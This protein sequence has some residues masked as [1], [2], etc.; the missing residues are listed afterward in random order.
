MKKQAWLLALSASV[1]MAACG[2]NNPTPSAS[3]PSASDS[4]DVSSSGDPSTESIDLSNSEVSVDVSTSSAEGSSAA[5]LSG[6]EAL[7][8]LGRNILL[9][10]VFS[11]AVLNTYSVPIFALASFGDDFSEYKLVDVIDGQGVW[12]T[13]GVV[14][15]VDQKGLFGYTY[16]AGEITI[17]KCAGNTLTPDN[18]LADLGY[19]APKSFLIQE[20]EMIEL[21]AY[22]IQDE[23]DEYAWEAFLEDPDTEVIFAPILNEICYDLIGFTYTL[24]AG[25]NYASVSEMKLVTSDTGDAGYVSATIALDPS[26]AAYYGLPQEFSGLLTLDNFDGGFSTQEGTLDQVLLSAHIAAE[27]FAESDDRPGLAANWGDLNAEFGNGIGQYVP[28]PA[29]NTYALAVDA[30]YISMNWVEVWDF[31]Y[32][33]QDVMRYIDDLTHAYGFVYDPEESPDDGLAF[34]KSYGEFGDKCILLTIYLEN[35]SK[36]APTFANDYFYM[37]VE[38]W[39]VGVSTFDDTNAMIAAKASAIDV[40]LP[41]FPELDFASA[42]ECH[43]YT[44]EA[45]TETQIYDAYFEVSVTVDNGE[46]ASYYVASV[47]ETL[48]EEGDNYKRTEEL[49]DGRILTIEADWDSKAEEE[50]TIDFVISV[51]VAFIATLD[52]VNGKIDFLN[53]TYEITV[54]V[55]TEAMNILA[56]NDPVFNNYPGYG[57]M[58]SLKLEFESLETATAFL[59]DYEEDLILADFVEYPDQPGIFHDLPGTN[60]VELGEPTPSTAS[61]G[62]VEGSTYTVTFDIYTA[63]V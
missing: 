15:L 44:A 4:G 18:M 12:E 29:G 40:E 9:S 5:P 14:P 58:L 6:E 38:S 50:T 8:A 2:N 25:Y 45:T 41:D 17:G 51:R 34:K 59:N 62:S 53:K 48:L 20:G 42:I 7:A 46:H 1:L 39:N 3:T 26:L 21:P 28:F 23:E 10:D 54:P 31:C 63:A 57:G 37:V 55:L 35:D 52:W 36:E 19:F 11:Y 13:G 16:D 61:L 24:L 33:K 22:L 27:D 47:V 32:D 43:D 30:E 49:V 56:I 60:L